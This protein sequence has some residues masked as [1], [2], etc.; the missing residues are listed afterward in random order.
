[1]AKKSKPNNFCW[2]VHSPYLHPLCESF[3]GLWNVGNT[4]KSEFQ[5]QFF[6]S[7]QNW[8]KFFYE[9]RPPLLANFP[10]NVVIEISR[11]K[12]A[13]RRHIC[14]GFLGFK[15]RAFIVR[16]SHAWRTL[17]I[18]S[19]REKTGTSHLNIWSRNH[20]NTSK[21]N[22]T[23]RQG[24]YWQVKVSELDGRRGQII[25]ETNSLMSTTFFAK[26][27]FATWIPEVS[28]NLAFHSRFHK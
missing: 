27:K 13:T 9:V 5:K 18:Y 10:A 2:Y 16:V 28:I 17:G 23:G 25:S 15:T 24:I 6:V 20:L 7:K 22:W 19:T 3:Y 12:K 14:F 11:K 1:M 4:E 21:A 26:A 8:C